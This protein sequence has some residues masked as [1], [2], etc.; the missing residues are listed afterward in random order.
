MPHF[1]G[2]HAGY[3]RKERGE[4]I[5]QYIRIK[6]IYGKEDVY[7]KGAGKNG[8]TGEIEASCKKQE[9]IKAWAGQGHAFICL[10]ER[11]LARTKGSLREPVSL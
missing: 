8:K 5:L 10:T 2:F 4:S 3:P 9:D 1:P 11:G 7:G 6:S